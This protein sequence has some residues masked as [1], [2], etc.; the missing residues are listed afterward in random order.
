ML[1]VKRITETAK[2][3]FKKYNT[4]SG[5][6]IHADE[7]IILTIGR[8]TKIKTG[9]CID[10]P[11]GYDGIMK[12]RSSLASKGVTTHGGV[13]DNA[14]TGEIL[15]LLKFQPSQQMLDDFENLSLDDFLKL[16]PEILFEDGNLFYKINSGDRIAQ[17]KITKSIHFD[18]VEVEEIPN[19]ERGDNGFGSTGKR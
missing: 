10:F 6:D 16:Y 4:D 1:K 13:I 17:M 9:I 14:Y 11:D 8:V 15:I 19:K 12:D 3:P 5:Y 18:V 2:L 7:D